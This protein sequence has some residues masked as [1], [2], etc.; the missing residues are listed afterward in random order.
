MN[1]HSVVLGRLITVTDTGIHLIDDQSKNTQEICV[2]WA[3]IAKA[4]LEVTF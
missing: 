3:D 2:V 1:K 4:R